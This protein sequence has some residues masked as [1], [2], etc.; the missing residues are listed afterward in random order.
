MNAKNAILYFLKEVPEW[1]TDF[2]QNCKEGLIDSLDEEYNVWS[3]G[4][5]PAL[6][7]VLTMPPPTRTY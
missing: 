5:F 3:F 1:K 2:E 6:S 7:P 4:R